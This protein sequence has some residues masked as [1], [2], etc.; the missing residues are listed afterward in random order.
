MGN[1]FE[2][3]LGLAAQV[4]NTVLSVPAQ[5]IGAAG[6]AVQQTG[7]L[8]GLGATGGTVETSP[9]TFS[10]A[11]DREGNPA[12]RVFVVHG[13]DREAWR[14]LKALIESLG[15]TAYDYDDQLAATATGA[16][17]VRDIV[18]EG[19]KKAKAIVV[20]FTPE[21]HAT[22]SPKLHVPTDKFHPAD[23]ERYQARPNVIFEAGMAF[24]L[25]PKQTVL[26]A[27]GPEVQLFSDAGGV[28]VHRMTSDNEDFRRM[29][30]NVLRN[31]GCEIDTSSN[32]YLTAGN[33]DKVISRSRRILN[34]FGRSKERRDAH[35]ERANGTG[36]PSHSG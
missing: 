7:Q 31:A 10:H 19:L 33:F 14:E 35:T 26:F 25:N 27:L 22:L 32:A 16:P 2:G 24:A 21:E 3:A 1:I 18:G 36:A 20:L 5:V 13:R 34:F 15:L 12:K 8:L 11:A 4:G 9:D 17:F 6:A 23:V 30:A 29:F 28:H